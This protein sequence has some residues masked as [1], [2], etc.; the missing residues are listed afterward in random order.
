MIL[1]LIL[2]DVIY[3]IFIYI[4]LIFV[5]YYVFYKIEWYFILLVCI[6]VYSGVIFSF[7]NND[8]KYY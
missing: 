6:F 4:E 1:F 5:I 7:K 8:D 2:F 3:M